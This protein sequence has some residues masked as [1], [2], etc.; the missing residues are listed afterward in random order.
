MRLKVVPPGDE[1]C[2]IHNNRTPA[3]YICE[4]CMRELGVESRSGQAIRRRPIRRLRSSLRRTRRRARRR[5]RSPGRREVV[6]AAALI[7][8]IAVT[9]LV[10]TNLTAGGGG[11]GGSGPPTQ[12]DVVNALGLSPDP[13]GTGWITLDGACAVLSIQV[14]ARP[15]ATT[16][17]T[18][19][20]GTGGEASN[21]DGTVRATVQNA[22]SQSQTA[23]VDRI[24]AALRAHF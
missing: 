18:A 5:L 23:C 10:V 1:R 24:S 8:A 12:E 22:F 14:G 15:H 13:S 20:T 6:I 11:G 4:D 21:A 17:T 9:I 19:T 2:D 16:T 7:A 3:S